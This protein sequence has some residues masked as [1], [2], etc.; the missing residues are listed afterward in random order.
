MTE[1]PTKY[2]P[3]E[4]RENREINYDVRKTSMFLS[5]STLFLF[6]PIVL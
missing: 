5:Y 6:C 4:E 1:R 3:M 2:H